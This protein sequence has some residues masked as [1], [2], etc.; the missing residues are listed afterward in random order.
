MDNYSK[1]RHIIPENDTKEHTEEIRLW[2]GFL[3]IP[4]C[5]C[6]PQPMLDPDT[7]GWAIVHTAFDGREALEEA[8]NIIN[9][10]P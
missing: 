3:P 6:L 8:N 1:I 4:K 2:I 5:E 7:G 10:K 9:S